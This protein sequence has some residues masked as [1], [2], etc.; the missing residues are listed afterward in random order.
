M[1][2]AKNLN[3]TYQI[4]NINTVAINNISLNVNKGDFTAI[5]G[6]S[7]CGKSTLLN[8]LGLLDSPTKGEY[9]FLGEE[10]SGLKEGI[11][12]K[13]RKGNIGFIFQNFNLIESMTVFENIELP[14]MYLKVNSRER[15]KKIN[16]ILE[17]MDIQNL[18][19]RYPFQLSGG[20]QQRVSLSRAIVFEPNLILADE[21]TGNL[22]NKNSHKIMQ[23]LTQINNKGITIVLVT[24]EL[25]C[26][27][28]CKEIINILDG[29][30]VQ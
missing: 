27:K 25:E 18:L 10:V 14:L 6:P 12:S 21:P 26:S 9:F 7:G 13:I 4:V 16:N 5:M 15:K 17:Y 3:K 23:L 2:S 8:I 1:I 11:R 22:D 29:N 24:H 20:E 19:N 28:Y 30:L